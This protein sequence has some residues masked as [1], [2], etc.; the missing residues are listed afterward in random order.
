MSSE[1][2]REY[3]ERMSAREVPKR[4]ENWLEKLAGLEFTDDVVLGDLLWEDAK[5]V[6]KNT[7][8][9]RGL[10][11]G[12][13]ATVSR[14]L[15]KVVSIYSKEGGVYNLTVGDLRDLTDEQLWLLG[16]IQI[17]SSGHRIAMDPLGWGGVG[18]IRALFGSREPGR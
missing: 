11:K 4:P 17:T 12:Q 9:E 6:F 14:A 18:I 3:L 13:R 15:I 5:K 10:T 16:S 8:M 7:L 1:V 2:L